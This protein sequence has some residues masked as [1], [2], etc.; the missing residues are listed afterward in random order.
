MLIHQLNCG[1]D[2]LVGG[3]LF[4]GVGRVVCAARLIETHARLVL[5]DAGYGVSRT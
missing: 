5:V 1:C 3:R 4:D 2:C